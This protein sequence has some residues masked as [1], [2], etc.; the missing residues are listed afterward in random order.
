MQSFASDKLGLSEDEYLRSHKRL[1]AAA[2]TALE[3]YV[4]QHPEPERKAARKQMLRASEALVPSRFRVHLRGSKRLPVA[5]EL[6]LEALGEALSAFAAEAKPG[7]EAYARVSEGM[8]ELERHESVGYDEH[9]QLFGEAEFARRLAAWLVVRPDARW[10]RGH[11]PTGK[12]EGLAGWYAQEGGYVDLARRRLRASAG[13]P[14]YQHGVA[15]LLER[16]DAAR[17]KLAGSEVV[18]IDGARAVVQKQ[19]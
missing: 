16:A 1:A 18:D 8:H 4:D 9:K 11:G 15:A 5:W 10:A 7:A 13:P 12:F 2:E 19:G 6:C 17:A 14:A 3:L